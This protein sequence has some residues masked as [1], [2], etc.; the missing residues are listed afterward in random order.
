MLRQILTELC[1]LSDPQFGNARLV[2]T[3]FQAMDETRS[4]RVINGGLDC[5]KEPFRPED[6]PPY[7]RSLVGT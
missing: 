2:E 1:T 5:I 7:F 6:I 4:S 3:L